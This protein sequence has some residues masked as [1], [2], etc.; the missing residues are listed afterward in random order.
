MLAKVLKRPSVSFWGKWNTKTSVKSHTKVFNHEL[1][2]SLKIYPSGH[3]GIGKSRIIKLI[4]FPKRQNIECAYKH[5]SEWEYQGE[6]SDWPAKDYNVQKQQLCVHDV[7][8]LLVKDRV[9][10]VRNNAMFI[11][12]KYLQPV[13][14]YNLS[15]RPAILERLEKP[16]PIH[17]LEILSFS[18]HFYMSSVRQRLVL[19]RLNGFFSNC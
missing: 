4:V 1:I 5:T 15:T 10:Y 14:S 7:A 2:K 11:Q 16:L 8:R 19:V 6:L 18:K 13:S 12:R 3:Y 9:V 17:V